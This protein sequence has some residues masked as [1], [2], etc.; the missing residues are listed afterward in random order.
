MALHVK[1]CNDISI[2]HNSIQ[3]CIGKCI[4]YSFYC[5]LQFSHLSEGTPYGVG[6]SNPVKS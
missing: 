2:P 4:F 6:G 3:I 1:E 5:T